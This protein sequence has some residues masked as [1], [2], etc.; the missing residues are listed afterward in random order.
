MAGVLAPA[1][2]DDW[3]ELTSETLSADRAL[4][5]V[6]RPACGAVACFVGTVRDHA[7]GHSGVTAIDYEAYT[8]Q[9]LPRFEAIAAAARER[10]EDL[11]GL[12]LWHR[13][14]HIELG[15]TSVVVVVSSSHRAEAFEACRYLIDTL[16]ATAP[17]W[18]H[19][20]WDGGTDWSLAARSV[21]PAPG[22]T[23]S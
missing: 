10:W 11:G 13:V 4:T 9:V 23:Q 8:G 22:V 3:L 15:E 2:G 20:T 6:E 16:K 12:V 17:I 21:E 18:K 1:Q 5:W 19:E 14:G 7:E